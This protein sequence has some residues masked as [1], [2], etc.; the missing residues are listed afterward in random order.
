MGA[1][2][3]K[4][5]IF[6]YLFSN[7]D[8]FKSIN[9]TNKNVIIDGY[10]L[11]YFTYYM[12]QEEDKSKCLTERNATNRFAYKA[13]SRK[14]RD[15]LQ[16]F[17]DKCENVWVVFDGN[18]EP[19]Q[20]RRPDPQRDS[21]IRFN[22]SRSRLP[23]LINNQLMSIVHDLKIKVRIAPDEA[24]PMIVQMARKHNAYIVGRD[25]DYFLYGDTNGYVPLD[26]LEFSTLQ[27]KYYH[28]QDVFQGMT[29]RGVALWATTIIYK[30]VKLDDLEVII[31]FS[32]LN[33]MSRCLLCEF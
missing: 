33:K 30:L 14:F 9:L 8:P 15:F 25:T 16:Q 28:M 6:Y 32:S 10:S 12:I 22:K 31:H 19:N 5:F 2:F 20:Y 7:K 13:L 18:Y 23:P 17:K 24:D 27:G 29:Q 3:F 1:P 4:T 21:T 11:F 26:K